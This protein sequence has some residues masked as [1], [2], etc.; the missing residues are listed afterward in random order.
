LEATNLYKYLRN[1]VINMGIED[2]F[3]VDEKERIRFIDENIVAR[4]SEEKRDSARQRATQIV[5]DYVGRDVDALSVLAYA[6]ERGNF[7]EFAGRL[8]AHYKE[9]LHY[10]HP[11]ARR[12]A[13]VP[14]AVR[15]EVF[16][17]DCYKEMGIE[18][19]TAQL[20]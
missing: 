20:R 17:L 13:K 19:K 12:C 3:Q 18:S 8:E 7:D 15:A 1:T 6:A 16:F 9:N 4:L 5:K 14:G 11:E 10:V 2:N